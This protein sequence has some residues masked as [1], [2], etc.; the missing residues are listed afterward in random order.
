METICTS[1]F[2]QSLISCMADFDLP[3]L[4]SLGDLVLLRMLSG[5]EPGRYAWRGLEVHPL[6]L[7]KKVVA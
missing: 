4:R 5:L 6:S 3:T 2:L 7:P 1:E